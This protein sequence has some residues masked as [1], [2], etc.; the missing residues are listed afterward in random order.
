MEVRETKE[1]VVSIVTDEL[2]EVMNLTSGEYEAVGQ[3]V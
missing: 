1:F 2:A 3:R